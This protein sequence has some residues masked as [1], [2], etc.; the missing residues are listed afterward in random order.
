ME[1]AAEAEAIVAGDSGALA[2]AASDATRRPVSGR[3][4]AIP[5]PVTVI[6][7]RPGWRAVDLKEL[8]AY[9]DLFRFLAWRT[10]KARYA[11]SA[12]GIGWAVIQPLFQTLVFTVV[13][14][15]IAGLKG[16][17]GTP[18]SL[19]TFV[20]LVAWTYFSGA[21]TDGTGSL[22]ANT[23]MISKVYFPRLVL[24][25]AAVVAKLVDF[26]IALVLLVVVMAGFYHVAPTW[27]VLWLP[28]LVALMMLSAAGMAIWLTA[29]A[30]QYR[31]VKYALTF[32][33]QLLMYASPVIYSTE[34]V[35]AR[36]DLGV[37]LPA[38]EGTVIAPRTIYALNPMVGVIE[39]FRAAFLGTG[40]M[41][42]DLLAI[43]GATALVVASSGCVYFRSRERLFA[44]VA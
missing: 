4:T 13:F 11:Q 3:G 29:L 36:L 38:L 10:I 7:H 44:D 40:P 42:W 39:G 18:Y 14:G 22:V 2:A 8:Y 32:M 31:D 34:K 33:V 9:R 26:G 21:L 37:V 17:G 12:L 24:P 27:N 15:Y 30:V 41:P 16:E 43:G 6:E 23:N 5:A 20:A 1:I 25:L 35:P 28:L 19:T